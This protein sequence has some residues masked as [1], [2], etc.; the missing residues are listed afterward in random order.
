[1]CFRECQNCQ[2]QLR[3]GRVDVK[4]KL[5][6]SRG[7][8]RAFWGYFGGILGRYWGIWEAF[9]GDCGAFRGRFGAKVAGLEEL[10]MVADGKM[11]RQLTRCFRSALLQKCLL[12]ALEARTLLTTVVPASQVMYHNDQYS[13]GDNLSETVLTPAN[14]NAT[15]YQYV[16]GPYI[17]GSGDNG[18]Y[19]AGSGDSVPRR[20]TTGTWCSCRSMGIMGIR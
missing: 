17:K 2:L 7:G 19:V 8:G 3:T 18:A 15:G 4:V 6:I 1:M 13:T 14:V 5:N 20:R 10:D 16:V 11:A 9:W 12:E